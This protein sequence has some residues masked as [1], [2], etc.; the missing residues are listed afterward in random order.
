MSQPAN[1][2]L[3][4]I[5]MEMGFL[6]PQS[7]HC[8]PSAA[9]T[10]PNCQ[11]A[12]AAARKRGIP[13]F[14]VIRQ[15][16]PD[17]SDV[18]IPRYPE[19]AAGGRA[20]APGSC[21]PLS[22]QM[23]PEL[24]PQAGDF[25]IVKPRWSA[26]FQTQLDLMLRR[27]DIETVVLAGTTTPNCVRTTCYDANALDYNVMV[28]EDCTSS[29]TDEIQRVN[30]EDMARMGATIADSVTFEARGVEGMENLRRQVHAKA[31]ESCAPRG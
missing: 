11:R 7:A 16:R 9:K 14:F 10:V 22:C 25:I 30:I 23:P 5:D 27:L 19:W 31:C 20:M 4:L 12:I 13:I 24:A 18:E 3:I 26:F 6:S 2:A 1:A 8:I 29:K 28:L 15:Y 17:G 21:G